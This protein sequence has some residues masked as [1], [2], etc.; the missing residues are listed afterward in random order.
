MSNILFIIGFIILGLAV[1]ILAF[2]GIAAIIINR[3][4]NKIFKYVINK[5]F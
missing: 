4:L 3:E 2:I 1:L 5:R